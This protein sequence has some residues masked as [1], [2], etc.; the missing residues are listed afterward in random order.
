MKKILLILVLGICLM[1]FVSAITW[2]NLGYYKLDGNANDEMSYANG[3]TNNVQQITGLLGQAYNFTNATTSWINLT[4]SKY[5]FTVTQPLSISL[6][7]KPYDR[8]GANIFTKQS[9]S[10][11]YKGWAIQRVYQGSDVT[12][13]R[14]LGF[15]MASEP[16][17]NMYVDVNATLL[18]NNVWTHI[19][20]TYNGTPNTGVK[21]YINGTSM[22]LSYLEG[23]NNLNTSSD[24]T[25]T[26]P[27]LIGNRDNGIDNDGFHGAIDEVGIWQRVLSPTEVNELYNS[28]NGLAFGGGSGSANAVLV[29]PSNTTVLSTIGANFTSNYT[30]SGFNMTNATYYVWKSDGTLFNQT[31]VP[32]TGNLTNTTTQFIDSFTVGDYLWN[33]KLCYSNS[34]GFS[35]CA[36]APSNNTFTVGATIGSETHNNITYETNSETFIMSV[37]LLEGSQ[38]SLANLVY[39]GIS[40]PV[41]NFTLSGNSSNQT[42]TLLKTIDIP[43]NNNSYS[44]KTNSFYWKFT[45]NGGQ[46]QTLSTYTQIAQ[47]LV[48]TQCN[49]T[50]PI[51]TLNFQFVDEL[52]QT[53]INATIYPTSILLNFK[54]WSGVG[55]VKKN[56]TFQNLSSTLNNY[57]FCINKNTTSYLDMDMQYY[58]A[59]GYAQRSYYFR[60]L[61]ISNITQN[62]NLYALLSSAATKFTVTLKQNTDFL[63]GAVIGVWK[64]F[65]GLGA[66]KQVMVGLTDDKGGFTANLDIDQTY[67]FTIYKDGTFYPA[68]IKQ[69]S[70][71]VAPCTI[72]LNIGEGA[73]SSFDPFYDYFAQNVDY[74][75]TYDDTSKLVNLDFIDKLGTAHYWRLYVYQSNL[76]NDTLN[77]ICDQTTYSPIGNMQCNYSN[78][79]GDIS[80]KV[81][82]SRSPEKLV[83]YINF[84]NNNASKIFGESGIFAAIIILLVVFFAGVRNPV[85]ALVLLPFALIVLKLIGFLPLDWTWIV[86]IS[87]FDI[88]IITRLKT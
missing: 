18:P 84:M 28:G 13:R 9:S 47:P 62:Y 52:N 78:Y 75:L 3:V 45:Y 31:T 37:A 19:T 83:E 5:N 49:S 8:Y 14:E 69:G 46:V 38:V 1:S 85:V 25:S 17:Y 22:P 79:T 43:L 40:Y 72:D 55:D 11:P 21:I 71:S 68:Q 81:F 16:S 77:V 2:D 15:I 63:T 20:I 48:L 82:I 53:N 36:F 41:S 54:Y 29:S 26:T 87:V 23:A 80:A 56:Y 32:V 61:S 64:Y 73:I 57:Q 44:N 30:I 60:N 74:N 70:C 24:V 50:Y 59:V 76:N 88:W 39:N 67:N 34:T 6:W 10:A 7:V 35:N 86:G 58:S 12:G 27:A 42:M 4:A 65:V 66:Y 33:T 51:T